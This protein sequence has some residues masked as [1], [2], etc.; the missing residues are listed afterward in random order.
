VPLAKAGGTAPPPNNT[1][2]TNMKTDAQRKAE[3]AYRKKSVKQ[4]IVKFYPGEQD[5]AIYEWIKSHENVTGY[6][7]ELV[8]ADMQASVE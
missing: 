2:V 7:K 6:L 8:I 3:N 1:T 5:E 4:V